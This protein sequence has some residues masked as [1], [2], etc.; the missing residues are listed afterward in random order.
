MTSS[1]SEP[2]AGAG[3]AL[4]PG[5]RQPP[6]RGPLVPMRQAEVRLDAG[7]AGAVTAR[8]REP[9]GPARWTFVYAPGAGSSIR[10]PFGLYAT[11]ALAAHQVS[12]LLFQFPYQEAK[13]RSPDRPA[14]LEATWRAA[15]AEARLRSSQRLVAGGRSMGGRMASHVVAA[16]ESVEALALFAYPLHPPGKPEQRR[17]AHLASIAVPVLFCS[18]DRDAFASVGELEELTPTLPDA[19][20]HVLAGADHGFGVLKASGRT[21]ED[22]WREAVEALLAFVEQKGARS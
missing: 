6:N 18:G 12:S 13:R 10:D 22:V 2:G 15:L 7:A 3:W 16:G 4:F 17:D 5:A 21:R 1:G 19:Q 11:Q 14:V 9:Q 20:L 8:W